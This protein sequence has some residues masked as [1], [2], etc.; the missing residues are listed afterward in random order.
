MGR[1]LGG[2]D[3]GGDILGGISRRQPLARASLAGEP[4]HPDLD[5]LVRTAS[6]IL[7]HDLERDLVHELA[8]RL[9]LRL[10]FGA[11][12]CLHAT[13]L[14]NCQSRQVWHCQ[15][16]CF[17]WY[18]DGLFFPIALQGKSKQGKGLRATFQVDGKRASAVRT[19]HPSWAPSPNYCRPAA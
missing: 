11:W 18:L 13:F 12:H 15:S 17:Q 6:A 2:E 14:A 9:G 4:G 1:S 16:P 7:A 5:L 10:L 3:L 19:T 8:V